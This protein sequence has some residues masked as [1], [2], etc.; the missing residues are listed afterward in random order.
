P[1]LRALSTPIA[2]PT[3]RDRAGSLEKTPATA[4]HAPS[5]SAAVRCITPIHDSGPPPTTPRRSGRPKR[6]LIPAMSPPVGKLSRRRRERRQAGSAHLRRAALHRAYR[7]DQAYDDSAFCASVPAPGDAI[8]NRQRG[9]TS[10]RRSSQ[11]ENQRATAY[12]RAPR[13]LVT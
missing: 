1:C 5:S 2:G 12:I 6:S 3:A 7:S 11:Q 9:I 8:L 10:W 4:R 13:V